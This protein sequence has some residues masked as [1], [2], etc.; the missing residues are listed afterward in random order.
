M[1][2]QTRECRVAEWADLVGVSIPDWACEE[3]QSLFGRPHRAREDARTRGET[4]RGD[5][6][7]R[8]DTPPGAPE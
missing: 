8:G 5:R 6:R 3:S 2:Q 4:V 1:N 7:E